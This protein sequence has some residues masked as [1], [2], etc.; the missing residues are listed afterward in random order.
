MTL[1]SLLLHHLFAISLLFTLLVWD[2]GYSGTLVLH[3][4]SSLHCRRKVRHVGLLL[5]PHT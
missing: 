4:C 2:S 5:I 1:L 3:I